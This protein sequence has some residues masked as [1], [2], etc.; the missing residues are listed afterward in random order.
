MH[1]SSLAEFNETAQIHKVTFAHGFLQNWGTRHLKSCPYLQRAAEH[2]H[3][4]G[5]TGC[6]QVQKKKSQVLGCLDV[7]LDA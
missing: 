2:P 6:L 1:M 4:H 7:D 5:K 3:L